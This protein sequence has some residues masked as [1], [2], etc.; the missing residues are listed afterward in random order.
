M[1]TFRNGSY[2]WP[3][4]K[5]QAITTI[6]VI[7]QTNLKFQKVVNTE[8]RAVSECRKQVGSCHQKCSL[9]R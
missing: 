5:N 3:S 1:D 9:E 2:S 6:A 8:F 4:R 7:F